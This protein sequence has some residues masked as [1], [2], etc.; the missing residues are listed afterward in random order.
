MDIAGK[1]KDF[2]IYVADDQESIREIVKETLVTAGYQVE[3]FS[4]G[5]SI[6]E[7]VKDSPPHLIMTDI[8]MPGMSG[9]QLLEKVKELSHDIEFIIMTSHASLETAVNAM[10]LGAYDYIHKPFENLT[11]LVNTADR[12]MSSVYMRLE[13]DQLLEELAEKNK[14]LATVN[15]RISQENQEIHLINALMQRL[16]Q[17]VDPDGVIQI[18]LDSISAL[19]EG[20]P[21]LFMKHLT[22]YSSLVATQASKIPI[23]QIKNLGINLADFDV[24]KLPEILMQPQKIGPLNEL[25][26]EVFKI[27][28]FYAFPFVFQDQP[29]GVVIVFHQVVN[30]AMRRLM[31]SFAQITRVSYDNAIMAKRIHEMAIKD[32]LTTLFNRRFFNEKLDEEIARS[33]RTRYPLSL[34]YLDIDHFKKYNDTNGHPMGDVVIKSVAQI[35][36]KTGRRSDVVARLGG[37]EF[38]IL[39]PHTSKEGAAIKAEKVRLIVEATKFPH[40]EKQP[41]GKVTIS[42]GV[43]EYPSVAIDAATLI[44]SSDDALYRVKQAGRNKVCL[45]EPPMGF[46]RE[47]EPLAVPMYAATGAPPSPGGSAA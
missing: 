46:Q 33:R 20:Q 31:E 2:T 14:L 24:K 9:I 40:G 47:F 13:N 16:N 34:V 41:M 12:A 4:S 39:C 8:R 29:M 26:G 37:E 11:D 23:D 30:E 43:S 38:A 22:A 3:T 1:R 44:K 21:V 5:E 27:P 17:R 32:P 10:K 15:K 19:V 36:I 25:M 18:F 42:L 28:Q 7:R 45:A 35:L 6:F